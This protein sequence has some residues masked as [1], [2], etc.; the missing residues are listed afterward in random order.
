MRKVENNINKKTRDK[1]NKK[2]IQTNTEE[3]L[4]FS[5]ENQLKLPNI[6]DCVKDG[7]RVKFEYFKGAELWYKTECGFLFPVPIGDVG[8]A[9]FLK[10]DKAMLFMRYI[11]KHIKVLESETNS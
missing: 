2:V 7:K 10:E 4:I 6:K 1:A 3:Y 11:R 5:K 8:D 9:T